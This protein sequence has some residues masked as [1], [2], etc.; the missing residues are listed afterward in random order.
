[1]RPT[2]PGAIIRKI[3]YTYCKFY[4]FDFAAALAPNLG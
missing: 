1:M 2:P 4:K 3:P